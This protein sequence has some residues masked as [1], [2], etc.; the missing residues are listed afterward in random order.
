MKVLNLLAENGFGGN[1][2]CEAMRFA[3]FAHISDPPLLVLQI[4]ISEA[5]FHHLIKTTVL[6]AKAAPLHSLAEVLAR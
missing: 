4:A 6:S 2:A 1:L 5:P 3:L